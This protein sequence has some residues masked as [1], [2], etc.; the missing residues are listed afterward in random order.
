[1]DAVNVEFAVR[2]REAVGRGEVEKDSEILVEELNLLDERKV[3]G[4]C[5]KFVVYGKSGKLAENAKIFESAVG[6]F[7]GF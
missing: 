4:G 7:F 1:M 2:R 6:M 3:L 5:K